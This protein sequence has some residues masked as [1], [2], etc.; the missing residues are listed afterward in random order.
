MRF[1]LSHVHAA[2]FLIKIYGLYIV[3]FL[4][5]KFCKLYTVFLSM[6]FYFL[7][8]AGRLLAILSASAQELS[9]PRAQPFL[10]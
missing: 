8:L 2:G 3:M 9:S 6:K 1:I 5:S 10:K 7:I 4:L